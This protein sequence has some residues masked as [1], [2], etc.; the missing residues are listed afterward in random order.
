MT[1]DSTNGGRK[2]RAA[3]RRERLEKAL[4]D[5]LRRRKAQAR[6]QQQTVS[7]PSSSGPTPPG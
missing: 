4:R 2:A 6:A 1:R 3:E 5:N 7:K